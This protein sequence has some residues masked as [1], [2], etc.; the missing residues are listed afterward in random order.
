MIRRFFSDE[1]GNY[2]LLTAVSI[3]PIM[4]A[5]A[6]GVDYAE[7]SKQRQQTLNALDAAGIATARVIL[8]GATDDAATAYAK[9]FFE[10]NLG[11]VEPANTSLTVLLPQ[12][13]T[14]GGTLKLTAGLKY[15]PYFFAA[16]AKMIGKTATD[17][18]F[19]ASSEVKLKNTVEVALVLDN[20]GSMSTIGTGSGKQR[21]VLLKEAATQLVE[22]LSNQAD[23]MQQVAKPVQ[24]ALVP[25]SASVNIGSNDTDEFDKIKAASWMD[26]DGISPIHHENFDWTSFTGTDNGVNRKVIKVGSIY[27][28]KGTNWG[29]ENG[30]KV[31]R[32]TLFDEMKYY[33]DS[34]QTTKANYTSWQGCVEARPYPYNIDDALPTASTPATLFVPMFAPDEAS[35]A[36]NDWFLYTRNGTSHYWSDV[37]LASDALSKQSYMPKYFDIASVGYVGRYR[38]VPAGMDVGPNRGCTTTPI[39]PLKDVSVNET[40]LAIED[41]IDDMQPTGNTNVPEGMAWGWRVLSHAAPYTDGRPESEKGNDKVVIVLTDGANTYSALNDGANNKSTYAALGYAGPV[42]FPAGYTISR[43]FQGTSVDNTTYSNSNYTA[44]MDQQFAKLCDNAKAANL[45]VITVS[46]DLRTTNAAEKKA[47][48]ALTA[49]ASTS[50]FTKDENGNPKILYFAATGATLKEEFEK[51]A[52][53]LSNLRIVG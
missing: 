28:K 20:S 30:K 42:H 11:S 10:T 53:E 24:F 47:I 39:T 3:V 33:T 12:N 45:M 34:A 8:E 36:D 13:N 49:C 44:A 48:D 17:V 26:Q 5:L 38:T 35:G 37:T 23:M 52:D 29:T 21:I 14:G 9:S 51:I 32:F 16:F 4:G 27:Y 22:T 18:D 43:V 15:K 6:L 1:R 31:T 2:A 19:S 40:K 41:A 7:M 46:L 50:R 25:F